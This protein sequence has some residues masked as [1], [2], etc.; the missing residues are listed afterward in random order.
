MSFSC[1]E[2]A[3]SASPKISHIN[4][5]RAGMNNRLL[6]FRRNRSLVIIKNSS[7]NIWL[8][9]RNDTELERKWRPLLG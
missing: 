7:A 9:G 5:V 6:L 3:P 4:V 2:S 8:I 1:C